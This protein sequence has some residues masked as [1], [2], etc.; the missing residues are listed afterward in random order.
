MKFKF[1][2][3]TLRNRRFDYTPMYYDERKEQL[4]SKKDH[5]RQME[6][7]MYDAEQRKTYLKENLKEE[8]SRS[9]IRHQHHRSA[10]LRIVLLIVLIL[11]L[12]YF[13]FNGVDQV[14]TVVKKIW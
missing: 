2:N 4:N 10:N 12:G 1:L 14:D 8:W 3:N 5:Y 13:I 9:H 11:A 6:E 7:K